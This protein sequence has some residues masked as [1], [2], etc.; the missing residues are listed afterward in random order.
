MEHVTAESLSVH[1]LP[2][3]LQQ[4]SDVFFLSG[5]SHRNHIEL[6]MTDYSQES[7]EFELSLRGLKE[8]WYDNVSGNLTRTEESLVPVNLKF[9]LK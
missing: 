4:K 9:K 8:Y 6:N 3:V 2:V 7:E 5:K 1:W